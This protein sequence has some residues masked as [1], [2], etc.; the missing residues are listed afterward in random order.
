MPLSPPIVVV[1]GATGFVGSHLTRALLACG[2]R[3]RALGRNAA[4]LEALCTAGAESISLDLRDAEALRDACRGADIVYH[5]G[6]LSAPWGPRRE[7]EAVNVLGTRHVVEACRAGR[8]RRLVH[9]SSPSVIFDGRDYRDVSDD[10]P[11]AARPVSVYSETKR[12]AEDVVNAAR[13]DVPSVIV[14]PKA[15]FGPGD[16]SLLPRLLAAARAGRLPQIG[17][18]RNVVD[19]TYVENV[20]HALLLAGESEAAVGNTYTVTNGEPAPPLW[21][22]VRSLIA[23]LG[24]RS[25]LRRLPLPVALAAVSLMEARARRTGREPL[26]TRYSVLIL[27]RTQTHDISRARRDLGYAPAVTLEEGIERTIAAFRGSA[28]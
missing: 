19:L 10:I 5:V 21:D 2:A 3:V 14:R 23:R 8:V 1:T 26:L 25:D 11:Y 13:A 18:G 17:D 7:F 16:T 15:V 27:A 22:V 12:R 28:S 6:A 4:A 20:V 9:V 24:L